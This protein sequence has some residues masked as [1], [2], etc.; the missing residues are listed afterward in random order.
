MHSIFAGR[1]RT[2]TR[3]ARTSHAKWIAA[4]A[5][6]RRAR[7]MYMYKCIVLRAPLKL[8]RLTLMPAHSEPLVGRRLVATRVKSMP[9]YTTVE[10]PTCVNVRARAVLGGL[11]VCLPSV[12]ALS[13]H[14]AAAAALPLSALHANDTARSA[15]SAACACALFVPNQ[16]MNLLWAR[17]L[18][19]TRHER[20]QRQTHTATHN[21]GACPRSAH[22]ETVATRSKRKRARA[23][24]RWP[25]RA[26]AQSRVGAPSEI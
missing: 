19:Y 26:R 20:T 22:A 4:A 16:C 23:T 12:L 5:A 9:N 13:L 3:H 25:H 7:R 11:S 14:V 24:L 18:H 17:T 10:Q 2:T 1:V 15:R 6:R 21:N 8:C